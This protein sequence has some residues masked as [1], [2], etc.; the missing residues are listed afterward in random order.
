M[1]CS[2]FQKAKGFCLG[3]L[4]SPVT[5]LLRVSQRA[6][7]YFWI[8]S[9]GKQPGTTESQLPIHP[10]IH[11]SIHL[12]IVHHPSIHHPT[13]INCHLL[14]N[15]R[16][17][18]YPLRAPSHLEFR[19]KHFPTMDRQHQPLAVSQHTEKQLTTQAVS[20]NF[21]IKGQV[22]LT[23]NLFLCGQL[24]VYYSCH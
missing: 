23:P 7:R 13:F 24:R 9:E 16:Y 1:P 4:H 15:E 8:N 3:V 21:R 14:Q 17:C 2:D 6:A 11:V 5:P 12:P 10:S 22:C 18:L 19:R 20:L